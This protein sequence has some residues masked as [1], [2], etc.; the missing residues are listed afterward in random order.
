M[1]TNPCDREDFP[2]SP[3]CLLVILLYVRILTFASQEA[4]PIGKGALGP[5]VKGDPQPVYQDFRAGDLRHSLADISKAQTL[6]GYAL[7]HDV[8]AGLQVAAPWYAG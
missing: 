4:F 3:F 7:S 8:R 1:A 2:F 6:L 5:A